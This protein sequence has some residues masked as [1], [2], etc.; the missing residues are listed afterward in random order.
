M[1]L[2]D[3][4]ARHFRGLHAGPSYVG[5][6]LQQ[7]LDGVDVREANTQIGSLNTIAKLTFHVN[8]YV[9]AVL[10]VFQG[11]P[12]EA[13]DKFSYN[14]PPIETNQDW[15]QLKTKVFNDAELLAN[16][17]EALPSDQLEAPFDKGK[18]GNNFRNINGLIEH[19]YYHL[20]QINIIKKLIREGQA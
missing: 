19:T 20:G 9:A 13:H 5:S 7:A 16:L 14:C 3:D 12:L 4:L 10:K 2:S 15:E 17:I 1:S 11:G 8:Y 18:Y 6:N